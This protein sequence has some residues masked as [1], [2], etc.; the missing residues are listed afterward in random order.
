MC[1]EC[2][3]EDPASAQHSVPLRTAGRDNALVFEKMD[4]TPDMKSPS[5]NVASLPAP[6]TKNTHSVERPHLWLDDVDPNTREALR[7][8]SSKET[9]V[10]SLSA[11]VPYETPQSSFDLSY[12]ATPVPE[13]VMNIERHPTGDGAGPADIRP[14]PKRKAN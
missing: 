7:G 14:S 5:P 4:F 9:Q 11:T 3:E 6:E 8:A 1:E 10:A 13:S 12:F 2:S